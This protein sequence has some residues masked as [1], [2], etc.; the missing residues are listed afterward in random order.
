MVTWASNA[1][2]GDHAD[3]VYAQRYKANGTKDGSE[4]RVNTHTNWNQRYPSIAALDSGKFVVVWQSNDQDASGTW[5]I[6][7]QRYNA[8]G[9]KDGSEFQVNTMTSDNQQ[10]PSVAALD[11]GKFVVTW[12][13]YG[14]DGDKNGIYAQRYNAD[15]TKY[16]NEF[17]GQHEHY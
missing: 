14:Q 16:G 9:T 3:G 15:G 2:D 10:F 7:A 5:G 1:Q 8:D 6:Y 13:S 4:F 12:H 17:R 11:S